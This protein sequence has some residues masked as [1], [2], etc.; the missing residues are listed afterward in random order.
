MY[1]SVLAI[2]LLREKI[3]ISNKIAFV[4]I[5]ILLVANVVVFFQSGA[6]VRDPTRGNVGELGDSKDSTDY[7]QVFDYI[8][9]IQIKCFS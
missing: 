3:Q 4:L 2:P 1:A 7:I 5:S 6:L 9:K 8:E